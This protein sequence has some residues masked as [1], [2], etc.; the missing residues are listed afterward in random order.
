MI[1]AKKLLILARKWQKLA[2]LK[3]KR[4]S[5]PRIV[6][7]PDAECCSTSNTVEKGHFVVYT[8]DQKRFVLPLEYLKNEIVRELFKL[9]EEEFGLVSNT[10]LT[11]PCDAVLLQYIIGLIQRHVTKEVEKALL[12]FIAS[13]HCSSSLYPLQADAS[14]QILICSF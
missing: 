11:L 5:I 2:V 14:Q 10:P 6:G 3:R 1:S 13:S 9:A 4:I 7:S 12:M 8:N